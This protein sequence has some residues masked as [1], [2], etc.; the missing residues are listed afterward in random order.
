MRYSRKSV[1]SRSRL[2]VWN[3]CP[4]P[5]VSHRLRAYRPETAIAEKFHA[6][7]VLGEANSRMRDFFDIHA[8]AQ[9]EHFIGQVLTNA[10]RATFDRRRTPIPA[11][12]PLALTLAFAAIP[13]KQIQWLGFLRRSGGITAPVELGE[14]IATVAPFLEPAI[15]AAQRGTALESTWPPGGPWKPATG[16]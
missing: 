9:H 16:A 4:I 11:R 15:A 13:Q 14:V 3:F 2:T 1:A 7:V 5:S 6:M 12:L 8:L 10:L